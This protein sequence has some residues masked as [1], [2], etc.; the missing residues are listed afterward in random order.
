MKPQLGLYKSKKTSQTTFT[1][2]LLYLL[3]YIIMQ[4]IQ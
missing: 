3:C 2:L 1:E 4:D